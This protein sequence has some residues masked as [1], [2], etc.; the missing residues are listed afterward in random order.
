MDSR[1]MKL[2]AA[3][4]ISRGAK[5]TDPAHVREQAEEEFEYVTRCIFRGSKRQE[6]FRGSGTPN[7]ALS[8]PNRS[9]VSPRIAQ[10]YLWQA[11]PTA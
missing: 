6:R 11:D 1:K 8:R 2:P 3:I 7:P 5:N 9:G 10:V 4:K